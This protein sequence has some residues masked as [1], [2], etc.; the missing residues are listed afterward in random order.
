MFSHE[1]EKAYLNKKTGENKKNWQYCFGI[2]VRSTNAIFRR[3]KHGD[4][5]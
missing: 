3:A 5:P 1:K 2:K 4:K